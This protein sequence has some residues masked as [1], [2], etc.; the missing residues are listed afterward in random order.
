M[1]RISSFY[2]V[3]IDALPSAALALVHLTRYDVHIE[4]W[5]LS[6]GRF[7]FFRDVHGPYDS[8]YFGFGY[9]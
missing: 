2:S 5:G 6:T 9:A 4:L 3:I 1:N 8:Q 7:K